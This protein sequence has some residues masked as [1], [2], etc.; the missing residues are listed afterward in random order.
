MLG[1]HPNEIPELRP[2]LAVVFSYEP[3]LAR[4]ERGIIP[5]TEWE[6]FFRA[7]GITDPDEQG[8]W[9]LYVGVIQGERVLAESE[10][11]ESEKA[12]QEVSARG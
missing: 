10:R 8:L 3:T 6:A 5:W 7:G 9:R 11:R 1:Q 4:D 2:D 12:G